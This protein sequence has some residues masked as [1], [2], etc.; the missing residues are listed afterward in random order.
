[1]LQGNY[2]GGELKKDDY[3]HGHHGMKL[4]D[5][6][7]HKHS[8]KCNLTEA[9]VLAVR[10]Y[11]TSSYGKLNNPLRSKCAD[12]SFH[13]PFKMTVYY[14][15]EGLKLLRTVAAQKEEEFSKRQLLYRGMKD[16]EMNTGDLMKI[17]GIDRA[18]MSTSIKIDTAVNYATVCIC[19]MNI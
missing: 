18:P 1:M 5:F 3:D 12:P 4:G 19:S 8:R 17:G 9:N 11:T 2:H 13:H 15:D 10:M 7:S 14:L 16:G 6:V